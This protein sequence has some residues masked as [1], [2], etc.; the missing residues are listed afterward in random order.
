M[1]AASSDNSDRVSPLKS[2]V[3]LGLSSAVFCSF[4]QPIIEQ[5]KPVAMMR[6]TRIVRATGVRCLDAQDIGAFLV[7]DAS[8]IFKNL[9]VRMLRGDLKLF[10]IIVS[11]LN[12]AGFL[13]I[14][15]LFR[16]KRH[17]AFTL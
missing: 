1:S 14:Y 5:L 6:D 9:C 16:E 10:N 4:L 3:V 17:V 11:F 12:V 2:P 7:E 15:H 13:L 8:K